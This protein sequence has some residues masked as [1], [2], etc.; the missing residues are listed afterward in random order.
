MVN[1]GTLLSNRIAVDEQKLQMR[2]WQMLDKV[3]ANARLQR[4]PHQL[5][6]THGGLGVRARRQKCLKMNKHLFR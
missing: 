2:T 3:F 5:Q 4:Q 6:S 1:I